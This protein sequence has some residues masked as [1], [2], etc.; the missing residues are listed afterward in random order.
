M[1]ARGGQ[2]ERIDP[3]R[4]RV[5]AGPVAN[6]CALAA[7]PMRIRSAAAALPA[8]AGDPRSCLCCP[9]CGCPAARRRSLSCAAPRL[10]RD[11]AAGRRAAALAL[12]GAFDG[13]G[14]FRG[15][16]PA[17]APS[18]AARRGGAPFGARP[19][20]GGRRRQ[21]HA[22]APGLGQADR[23]HLLRGA[24]AVLAAAHVLHFFPNEL[25]GLGGRRLPLA[26]I[27]A[28]ALERGLFRHAGVRA[29][30]V[31]AVETGY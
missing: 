28:S 5:P 31:P 2:G 6:R 30:D 16:A 24:R 29:K 18:G 1:R 3:V 20:T 23:D 11:G 10:S 4:R 13:P 27:L 7:S 19:G 17:A 14:S 12:E 9:A 8:A 22:C 26:F 15:C 21:L 25:T